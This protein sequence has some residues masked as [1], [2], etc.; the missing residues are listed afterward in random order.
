MSEVLQKNVIDNLS[1]FLSKKIPKRLKGV[2]LKNFKVKYEGHYGPMYMVD[3]SLEEG[4]KNDECQQIKIYNEIE[5][6][7]GFY[8]INECFHLKVVGQ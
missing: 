8:G 5:S 4:M 7:L 2:E 3:V 6:L 1:V